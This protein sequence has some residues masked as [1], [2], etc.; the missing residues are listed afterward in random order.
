[1]QKWEHRP[2]LVNGTYVQPIPMSQGGKENF[3]HQEYPKMLYKAEAAD[4]GPQISGQI[5]V[6]D[7]AQE[8]MQTGMGWC[9]SQLDAIARVHAQH[10]E[11]AKLA[12][13]RV[14]NDR[15]MSDHA[16]AE[17]DAYDSSISEHVP[18]IPE[19]PKARRGRPVKVQES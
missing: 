5:I 6:H 18:V 11:F 7:D 1:M 13:N 10:T 15:L 2:V 9:A 16:K 3:P 17:A 14:Y 8:A 19:Q 12:A 4:G